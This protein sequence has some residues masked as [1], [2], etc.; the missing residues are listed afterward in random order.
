MNKVLL[1]KYLSNDI[2]GIISQY[3]DYSI[4]K[5]EQNII[6]YSN[7]KYVFKDP[8]ITLLD[9]LVISSKIGY[10]GILMGDRIY[11]QL[12]ISGMMRDENLKIEHENYNKFHYIWMSKLN[13][14]YDKIAHILG[15]NVLKLIFI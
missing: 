15:L 4:N 12:N 2:I 3:L 7:S 13:D 9:L 6:K 5:M 8:N 14:K 1:T 10:S 11:D